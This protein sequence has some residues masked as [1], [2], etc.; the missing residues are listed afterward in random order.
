MDLVP[1]RCL[2]P[3]H[4]R[5]IGKT[6]QWLADRVGLSKQHMSDY[7]NMRHIM[8]MVIAKKIANE[9]GVEIDSLYD[10]EWQQE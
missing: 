8:G 2:I 7:I 10:W 5:K 6:Q 4:L 9:L 1:I 3:K